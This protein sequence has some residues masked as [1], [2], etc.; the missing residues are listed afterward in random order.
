MVAH[1]V[2]FVCELIPPVWLTNAHL[3]FEG[4][5]NALALLNVP[6]AQ[7]CEDTVNEGHW[8][9][10][11]FHY[12]I[13]KFFEGL[14]TIYTISVLSS[15]SDKNRS[16]NIF[17]YWAANKKKNNILLLKKVWRLKKEKKN[18]T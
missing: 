4:L 1:S 7:P 9:M 11:Q 14:N 15:L 10:S 5:S 18:L 12:L 17:C 3:G 13:V 8:Q 6:L 16:V 2:L